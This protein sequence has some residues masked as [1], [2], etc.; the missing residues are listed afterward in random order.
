MTTRSAEMNLGDGGAS[1]AASAPADQLRSRAG[2]TV[3]KSGPL[4]IS[5][6][7][8][9]WTSWKKRWFILTRT[10]LV[11]FRTDPSAI[12]Q[13]GSEVNL[14][15]GGIDLNSS[16]S[17]VVKDDKKLLTVL[18]P[19]GRAF[20]LKA[21]TTED[22]YDWK[23][24][25]ESAL[26]QAP[27][28]AIVMGQNILAQNETAE[29]TDWPP[30]QLV[31]KEKQ[32]VKSLVVGR[33]ILLAL[34][35]VDGSPTFL[36]KALTFIEQHGVKV[37]GILRQ[38]ADVDDVERRVREYEQGKDEFSPE[39]DAHVIGDCIKHILRELPSSPVPASCCNALLQA[40]RSERGRRI[41]AMREVISE[42]FP[43]PNRR[44][45]QRILNMMQVVASHK[46]VNRM[47]PSAVAACMAPLL[48][49]PLLAGECELENDFNVGG[50]GSVQLLQAAA[51]A[52]HAQTIAITLLEEYD[53]IFGHDNLQESSV[54]PELESDSEESGS[55]E[56]EQTDDEDILEDDEYL[57]SQHDSEVN[58][59]DDLEGELSENES[60]G[61]D[62]D[63]QDN[64]VSEGSNSDSG[65]SESSEHS[66]NNQKTP[67]SEGQTSLPQHDNVQI[68]KSSQ[69]QDHSSSTMPNKESHEPPKIVPASSSATRPKNQYVSSPILPSATKSGEPA[70]WGFR[71][72]DYLPFV[73]R[74][75]I[76]GRTPARKNL[77]MESIDFPVEEEAAIERLEAIKTDLQNKIARE[78]K[79]NDV[80]HKHLQRRKMD[81]NER[82]LAL[83]KDIESLKEQLQKERDLKAAM[84]ARLKTPNG[85]MPV[86]PALDDKTKA[87]L[88]EIARAEE[89]VSNLTKKADELRSQLD[90]QC[91]ENNSS[92]SVPSNQTPQTGNSQAIKIDLQEDVEDRGPPPL[93]KPT[94][95]EETSRRT[96]KPPGKSY[97]PREV[98]DTK[99][100][101]DLNVLE[102]N[103]S[104]GA[105]SSS[106]STEPANMPSSASSNNSL[107]SNLS[108]GNSS[109]ASSSSM[110]LAIVAPSA[111]SNSNKSSVKA[112][113]SETNLNGLESNMTLGAI[114]SSSSLEPADIA[115]SASSNSWK[116]S[117][118]G[119]TREVNLNGL[120]S[121]ISISR[122]ASSSSKEPVNTTYTASSNSQKSS[123]NELRTNTTS[124]ALSKR[125]NRLNV[126]KEW[127]TQIT[128]EIENAEKSRGSG[129]QSVENLP[130]SS[131]R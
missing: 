104:T 129:A 49:R 11:F 98:P 111:L 20:T 102:S 32:P 131:S 50:D 113:K 72:G 16:G 80:L 14:T 31:E 5:S 38:A 70:Y 51:A 56:Y 43:E 13:R 59:D 23:T 63:Q 84:E 21:E 88:A 103:I 95:I 126:S 94:K 74:P 18:F 73:K 25:L 107:E 85:C 100:E 105:T 99:R 75:N 53:K 37:E 29:T 121:N 69:N 30:E 40:C 17:V 89:D 79:E 45:L 123:A 48:L 120:E 92:V 58:T 35:D 36:E 96:G 7:G 108:M 9:G 82:R 65:F 44:L 81:L 110:G 86:S 33:P 67:S 42:T 55:E 78:V 101:M 117:G 124:H 10:S 2:N 97:L 66:E 61:A 34:E 115:S 4:Y 76:W 114:L 15:L 125:T 8:I 22:L 91:N 87:E 6:K 77:S 28:A 41:K 83:E 93:E 27:S 3:F 1:Y 127:Q 118:K 62:D 24:A 12:P 46:S 26:A 52:N 119:E 57:D 130:R 68:N 116:S 54:T 122:T 19:D 60:S 39:E 64:E 112:E 109:T 106:S 71:P 90:Q 47:S 128:N